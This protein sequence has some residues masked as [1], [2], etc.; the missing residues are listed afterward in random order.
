MDDQGIV[1]L[2]WQRSEQA[3]SETAAKYG[4]YCYAIACRI[5]RN[6]EDA[7]E[8]V[9]DTYN[10][11]WNAIPPHRPSVLSTFLG[12]ITRRLSIDKFRHRNAAK[13]GGGEM[14]LVL[15]ELRDCAA[16]GESM[17]QVYEKKR[18]SRVVNAFVIS[19]PET[20]QKV[21]LCRYWYMDS[22]EAICRQFAFSES[23]VK[24]MLY[25]TRAKLR[26]TLI[27]EGFQ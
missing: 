20:E 8:A 26:K 1:E 3:I 23:K 24:S 2:Y 14:P 10:E 11:A 6:D 5:L 13:R 19:L 15:D 7:Q 27:K 22:I 16:S 25:R 18:L 21:F 9:N 17:E 12:K 4:M